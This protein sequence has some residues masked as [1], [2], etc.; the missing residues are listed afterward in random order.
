MPIMSKRRLWGVK[1]MAENALT[2][3]NRWIFSQS[4][5]DPALKGMGTTFSSL[6]LIGSQA[7]VI[8]LGDTRIYRLRN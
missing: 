2:S 1:R 6:I 4:S 3:I 5:R 8:H 7:H